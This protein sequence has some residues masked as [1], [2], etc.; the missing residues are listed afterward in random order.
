V[1]GK[2]IKLTRREFIRVGTGVAAGTLLAACGAPPTAQPTTAPATVPT[3]VPPTV[4]KEV[5]KLR[6]WGGVPEANG[7]KQMVEAW[8]KLHPDVQ[9]EYVQYS[10]NDEGNIKLDTAL[11][12]PGEVDVYTTYGLTRHKKRADGGLVEPLDAYLKKSNLDASK[13][14][15]I[16]NATWDGKTWCLIGTHQPWFCFLNKNAF[17][18]AGIAIPKDW[19]W[20][21]FADIAKKLTKGSGAQKRYGA[22]FVTGGDPFASDMVHARKGGDYMFK[23]KCT[24]RW[25]DS[26]YRWAFETRLQMEQVDKSALPYGDMIAGK[27][28]AYN[29]FYQGNAAILIQS[30]W[31]TRYTKNLKDFPRDFVTSFAPMPHPKG[32][33]NT[34]RPGIADDRISLSSKS[35]YKDAAWDFLKWQATEGY[36]YMAPFGRIGYW[37]GTKPEDSVKAFLTD[38]PGYEKVLDAEAF[39][40]AIFSDAGKE[41]HFLSN[42]NGAAEIGQVYIEEA[43]KILIGEQKV[44][45]GLANLERRSNEALTKLSCKV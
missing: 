29:V 19:T 25:N 15:G 22:F 13:E 2:Q 14:F 3:T 9:V 16:S 31:I 39:Q 26:L 12:V 43:G 20:E 40:R 33:P 4:K 21:D 18:E 30:L 24:T 6:W 36:L 10:N 1:D 34:Y 42:T 37:K 44:D 7:P 38:L 28:Q 27:L 5:V 11:L 35:K 45:A 23:D 17:D 8:N 32:E 41:Y